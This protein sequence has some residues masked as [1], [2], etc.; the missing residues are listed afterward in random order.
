MKK[1]SKYILPALVAAFALA[2]VI[3]TPYVMAESGY[4]MHSYHD[5]AKSH[6][7]HWAIQVEG[8]EG[9][10]PIT[11]DSDKATLKE[12]AI[13][14]S[15][16][17]ADY[18]NVKKAKLG[19]AINENG[20]KFLVW[21]LVDFSK[22][23]ESGTTK[24]TIYIVDAGDADNTTE[25]TKEFDKSSHHDKWAHYKGMKDKFADM[26]PEEREAKFAQYKEMKEAFASISEEDQATIM[27]HFKNMKGEFADLTE[28]EKAAK[29]A[30]LKQQM[31]AFLGL[32][33]DEK[34]NYLKHLAMS[35]RNQA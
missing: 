29:H 6:K 32:N 30:E 4:G 22:D 7:G 18:P 35:L 2:F 20:D 15:E 1:T 11:E 33:L 8:F 27:S 16:A 23:S 19:K 14:L 28:E 25:I 31:E 21:K 3:A 9:S 5:G 34:I 26:T 24:M 10:I 12:K 17:A 13:P